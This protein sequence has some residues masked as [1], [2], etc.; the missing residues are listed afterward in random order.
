MENVTYALGIT[1]QTR[2]ATFFPLVTQYLGMLQLLTAVQILLHSYARTTSRVQYCKP[3]VVPKPTENENQSSTHFVL[4]TI[5]KKKLDQDCKISTCKIKVCRVKTS[6]AYF[7]AFWFNGTHASTPLQCRNGLSNIVANEKAALSKYFAFIRLLY[8]HYR[9]HSKWK[10]GSRTKTWYI[11]WKKISHS[12]W[13]SKRW[14]ILWHKNKTMK[15]IVVTAF[16][17]EL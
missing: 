11:S 14:S 6:T 15:Q 9:F 5:L 2:H 16:A 13:K 4:E 12:R 7:P 17:T 1:A 8:R 3:D 10:W